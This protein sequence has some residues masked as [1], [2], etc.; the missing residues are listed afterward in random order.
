MTQLPNETKGPY[1]LVFPLLGIPS[2]LPGG[3]GSLFP[4]T[5]PIIAVGGA[6]VDTLRT[7]YWPT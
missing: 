4:R 2:E 7:Y 5:P 1:R 6:L 3:C